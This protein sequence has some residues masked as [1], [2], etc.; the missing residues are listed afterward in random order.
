MPLFAAKIQRSF[1]S[2]IGETFQGVIGGV[3]IYLEQIS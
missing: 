1:N 2:Y 3:P